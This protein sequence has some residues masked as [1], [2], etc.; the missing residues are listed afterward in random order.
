MMLSRLSDFS[1]A[2]LERCLGYNVLVA[3]AQIKECLSLSDTSPEHL[4]RLAAFSHMGV[5]QKWLVE[6]T[7]ST[8]LLVHGNFDHLDGNSPLLYLCARLIQEYA[9]IGNVAVL[10]YFC[11][12]RADRWSPTANAAG[13]ISQ[14]AG[15]LLSH[16]TMC[17]NFDLGSVTSNSLKKYKKHNLKSLCQLFLDLIHQLRHKPVIIFCLIDSISVY[18]NKALL[19]DTETLLATL[20]ALVNSQRGDRRKKSAKVVMK[21]LVTD[22]GS[23]K[24]VYKQFQSNEVLDMTADLDE[25]DEEDLQIGD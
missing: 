22:A 23:T 20:L 25:G 12:L 16:P 2:E 18:E 6:E 24:Y 14:M 19:K 9:G 13:I 17:F 15:Q 1:T 3:E 8:A 5:F 4:R 11:G 10:H 21:L 7:S